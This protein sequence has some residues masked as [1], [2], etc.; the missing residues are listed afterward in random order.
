M[1]EW[2]R[3]IGF[4]WGRWM[5]GSMESWVRRWSGEKWGKWSSSRY[6]YVYL[7]KH[8]HEVFETFKVFQKEVENQLGKTIKSIHSDRGGE[9]M[10]QEF[11]DHLKDHGIITHRT[12]PYT[13]QH[14][15]VSERRNRTLLDMVRF[16]MSQITLP[17]SFWDYALETVTCILNM[18][19]ETLVKQDTLTKP[20]KL[21]PRSIKCI[22][23]GYPKETM[24]YSFYYPPENKVLVARIAEFLENSL[25]DQETSGSLEDLEIVQEEDTYPSLDTSLN[26]EEDDLEI[27]EPQSEIVPIHRSIRTRHSPD[28]MCLYIDAEEHELGDLEE[29][30][31]YKAALLDPEI[32]SL[33]LY[34]KQIAKELM[35][36]KWLFK[37]KTD[38]DGNVHIYKA[39]L[40]VKGFTQTPGIDYEATFS[41]VADIR[42]IRIL[43]AIAAYYDYEIWQ[44]DVKIAFLNGYL[45]EE[46]YR[47]RSKRLIGLCQSAY[48]EKILKRFYMENSKRGSIL[49]QEKLKLSK[50][51]DASTLAETG[52]VFILNGGAVD[53]KSTNQSIFTTSFVEAKYIAASDASKEAMTTLLAN[54]S[55]FRGFF[56]KQ[57]LIGPNFIDWYRQLRIV[58]SIED[59]LNY[60]EQPI[61][62]APVVPAG[63][64]VTP[65]ILV[66]HNAWIKGSK[67]IAGLMLMTM[68]PEIQRNL[69]TLHAHEM[70]LELKTLF[71]QQAE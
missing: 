48:I 60:L 62:L 5:E 39:R 4:L 61:P 20:D 24:G 32:N 30:T 36:D 15:G 57:K 16:M 56:E 37:K 58:I 8:K 40:V 46:I 68:E 49:M 47:D 19:C 44:M 2:N 69:E 43:I 41:P 34:R 1:A 53:W 55:V 23:V 28:R 45:N 42:A 21:E 27:D 70:L 71:S 67:E 65:E 11:L 3:V 17:K 59:K 38:M 7:L 12:P 26:H 6:G 52:Y 33:F 54:N 51:Q 63:Q 29:P 13:P 31:N 22:F 9:Y 10:S 64:H 25:I 14:N 50:S 18:G 35:K 66:A